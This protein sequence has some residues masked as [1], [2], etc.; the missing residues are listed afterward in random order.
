MAP[1]TPP[2]PRKRK[3]TRMGRYGPRVAGS[4]KPAERYHL[5]KGNPDVKRRAPRRRKKT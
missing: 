2:P 4:K 5:D 3:P 1:R